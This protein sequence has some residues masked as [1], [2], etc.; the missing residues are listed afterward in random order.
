MTA[1]RDTSHQSD[2]AKL[3][4]EADGSFKRA[5]SVFRHFIEKGG[6]FEAERDRYHLYVSYS[7]PWATRTLIVRKLKGLEDIIPVTVVS[8]HMGKD[9]WP[10][11]SVDAY[12]GADV[13]PLYNA[14]HVKD[15]YFKADPDYTGRFTVPVL[16]DKKNHTIVNN[17]SSEIIRVF[18]TAFNDIIPADKAAIDIYP[19]AHRAEIDSINEWVYDT[20]NNGVYKSGFAQSQ[21]AYEKAVVPL[22]NS[23]DRL[24]KIL[25][26]KDYLVGNTL[27]EADVRLFVTIIRFD[28]VYV[29]HFK[30]NIR[31]IRHGYPAIHSWMKKLYWN[32]D[33]F[34]STTNFDHIKTHYYWS[35]I[36]VNPS[37][38]VA[39]GPI[40]NIEP[41]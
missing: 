20:V 41:L 6:K 23:L 3:K 10:F 25:T 26:G 30:C 24:E 2:I 32:N 9:G 28:P 27:T 16:W 35:Q 1:K 18:N 8:P 36:L 13:D 11:A 15:L 38:V 31:T 34:Q 33:A 7:C 21:E 29:G 37:R 4:T 5:A 14:S 17:E 12:P 19:E 22:F 40:P 39:V